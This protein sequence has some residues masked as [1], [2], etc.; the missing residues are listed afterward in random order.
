MK[1]LELQI[2]QVETL[3]QD[4]C[5]DIEQ[6]EEEKFNYTSELNEKKITIS[7]LQ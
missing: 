4:L 1:D 6:Y 2:Y 5:N 3:N 7:E